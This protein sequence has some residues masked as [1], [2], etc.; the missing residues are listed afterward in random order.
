MLSTAMKKDNLYAKCIC[1]EVAVTDEGR[2]SGWDGA[3]RHDL[4]GL[5][6]TIRTATPLFDTRCT[7]ATSSSIAVLPV[8]SHE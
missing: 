1:R 3:V 2:F 8:T 7:E 5:N 6:K 4:L